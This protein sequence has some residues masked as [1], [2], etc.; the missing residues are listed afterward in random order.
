MEILNLEGHPSCI[1][2]SRVTA[3]LL[4]GWILPIRQSVEASWWRVCY[5][6][7]LPRL[8][9]ILSNIFDHMNEASNLNFFNLVRVVLLKFNHKLYKIYFT[10][11]LT[12]PIFQNSATK[13][14]VRCSQ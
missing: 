13:N 3:I 14:T 1:T 7:G 9:Y 5:Q 10:A 2:G 6:G 4:N 12:I 11:Y 8:V